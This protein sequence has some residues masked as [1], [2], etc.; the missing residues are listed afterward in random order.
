[1][2]VKHFIKLF[3]VSFLSLHTLSLTPHR[4]TAV[5]GKR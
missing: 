1:M 5:K 2:V 3:I 4:I